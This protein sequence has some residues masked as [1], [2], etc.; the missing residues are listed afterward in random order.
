MCL[1]VHQPKATKFSNEFLADVY[2]ANRDGLGIMYAD[3]GNVVVEKALPASADDFIAFYREHAGERECVWHAR[4]RTHGDIDLSNCH[5]YEVTSRVWLAHNGVLS[6]GNDWDPSKSDTWHFIRNIVEPAVAFDESLVLDDEWQSFLGGLIGASNKFGIVTAAGDVVVINRKSGVTYN[7]AWLS[8]TYAWSASKFGV[9]AGAHRYASTR[10]WDSYDWDTGYQWTL[11]AS[12]KSKPAASKP[13]ASAG[14]SMSKVYRAARNSYVRGTLVQWVHDAP[15]K[16]AQL[17]EVI[18]DD[19]SGDAAA[20]A[21]ND[22]AQAAVAI[23]DW[24]DRDG[25]EPLDEGGLGDM[26]GELFVD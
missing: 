24:F 11:G 10:V 9:G 4:M 2:S 15:G 5:P 18:A 22:P 6:S 8:N 25:Y 16:A 17:L 1:L 19:E 14:G 13:A 23:G 21:W 20:I 3:R 12:S 26:R 7:G